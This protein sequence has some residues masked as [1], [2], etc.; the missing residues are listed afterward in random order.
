ML[1]GVKEGKTALFGER[2]VQDCQLDGAGKTCTVFDMR[3]VLR[4]VTLPS[5][6]Y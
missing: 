1:V 6:R 2:P 5:L 3:S 4:S